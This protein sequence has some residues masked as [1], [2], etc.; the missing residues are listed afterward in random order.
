MGSSELAIRLHATARRSYVHSSC[1]IGLPTS[2]VPGTTRARYV[3]CIPAIL[4]NVAIQNTSRQ[5][6]ER[7]TKQTWPGRGVPL[8]A[9]AICQRL[10]LKVSHVVIAAEPSGTRNEFREGTLITLG[11]VQN[12]FEGPIIIQVQNSLRKK[13]KRSSRPTGRDTLA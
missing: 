9:T 3:G 1:P 10:I 5:G 11:C 7:R 2:S 12:Q 6:P 4:P 13:P 8:Q